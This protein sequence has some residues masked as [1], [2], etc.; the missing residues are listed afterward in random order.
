MP[1]MADAITIASRNQL[2]A[3]PESLCALPLQELNISNNHIAVLPDSFGQ[4]T[5]LR[6]FVRSY[7]AHC[8][9]RHCA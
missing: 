3:L 9:S 7:F 2:T 4:L 6:E 5:V 8:L 1:S